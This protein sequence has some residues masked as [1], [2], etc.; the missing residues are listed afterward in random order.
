M[1]T[2][3]DVACLAGVSIATASCAMNNSPS[4][5]EKTKMKVLEAARELNYIPNKTARNLKKQKTETIGL[6]I[7]DFGGPFYS[8]LVR[9]VQEV[10]LMNNYDLIVCSTYGG[11]NSTGYSFMKEKI[12]DGAI[13]LATNLTDEQIRDV[14]RNN[15]PIVVLDRELEGEGISNVLISNFKG[16][17]DATKH[18]LEIGRRKIGCILGPIDSYD[19]NERYRGYLQALEEYSMPVNPNF[20]VRGGFTEESGYKAARL[21]LA[22][23]IPDAIFCANDEMAIGALKAIR[24]ENLSV[25]QDIALAGFDD[26][27]LVSYITP[28]LT[29]ISHPRYTLGT[30]A[31]QVLFQM[32]NN[33]NK[34]EKIIIPTKLIVRDSTR[35]RNAREKL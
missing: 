33:G 16:A 8:E 7:S 4:V 35:N 30:T 15:Y 20:I 1:G 3:K 17:Y 31:A 14:T 28:A 22:S 25:P 12:V 23:E 11:V 19:A 18:L 21:M 32:L 10:V 26:I 27:L 6:F 9:G 24:E 34:S 5:T 29:T 13:V 2:L